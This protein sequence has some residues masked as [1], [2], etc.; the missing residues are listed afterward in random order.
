M[1]KEIFINEASFFV[2]LPS[3]IIIAAAG[4]I[5]LS[6]SMSKIAYI[7]LSGGGALLPG[8]QKAESHF[9]L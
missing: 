3:I 4:L 6:F 8:R 1:R 7:L 5:S 2:S 9:E